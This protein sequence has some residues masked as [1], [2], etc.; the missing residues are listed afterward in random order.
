M[1]KSKV[2]IRVA[3]ILLIVAFSIVGI[4]ACSGDGITGGGGRGYYSSVSDGGNTPSTPDYTPNLPS[5][6]T[7]SQ[8]TDTIPTFP[9]GNPIAPDDKPSFPNDNPGDY[10]DLRVPFV[11]EKGYTNVSYKDT[12]K[13]KQLW[14]DQ[15]NR[16]ALNDGKI[17]AIRNR[18]NNRGPND[19]QSGDQDYYYFDD[20]GDIVYKPD[21][22]VVKKF[23]GAAIVR[24]RDTEIERGHYQLFGG[25]DNTSAIVSTKWSERKHDGKPLHTVGGIYVNALTTEQVRA[26][27]F[28]GVKQGV[29]DF[30]TYWHAVELNHYG[31]GYENEIFE[32][33][34]ITTGFVEILVMYDHWEGGHPYIGT[35]AAVHSYFPYYGRRNTTNGFN[36]QTMYYMTNHNRY[37]G[38]RP[39]YVMNQLN[40]TAL[41]TAIGYRK[42]HFLFLPGHKY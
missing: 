24:Y 4:I 18:A 32:R 36:A 26:N 28:G 10:Y 5:D 21:R 19:F 42:W 23:M 22:T 6:N 3:V 17:F 31:W 35:G 14:L 37:I 39:E 41:F 38:E 12:N 20:N 40:C 1:I 9:D 7:N 25:N 34:Y 16:T 29:F 2:L 11:V 15:I 8:G 30:I 33:Q 27:Y 13:I